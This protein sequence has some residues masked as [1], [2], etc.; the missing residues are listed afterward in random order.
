[1]GVENKKLGSDFEKAVCDS[2]SALGWWVHF[3][4]PDSRGAQPF[5]IIAVKNGK[6]IAL[7]CKTS[8]SHIFN[9]RRIEENQ[10]MA[11][12]KWM[13]CNNGIPYIAILYNDDLYMIKYTRFG[14]DKSIN[15][16]NEEENIW[17]QGFNEFVEE[18]RNR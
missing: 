8:S 15:L 3:I 9:V 17:I 2:F 7:D 1:M 6:P 14:L 16:K 10:H 12:Q 5:D 18:V 13:R 4:A 11:F